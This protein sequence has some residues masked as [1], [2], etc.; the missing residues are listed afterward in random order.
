LISDRAK[1]RMIVITQREEDERTDEASREGGLPWMTTTA[2]TDGTR[3]T[4]TAVRR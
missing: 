2:T 3:V 1:R 4:A